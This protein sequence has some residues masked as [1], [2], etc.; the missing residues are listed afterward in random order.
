DRQRWIDAAKQRITEGIAQPLAQSQLGRDL[1]LLIKRRLKEYYERCRRSAEQ[2]ATIG[3][4]DDYVDAVS[5]LMART[6]SW[7][8]MDEIDQISQAISSVPNPKV[9]PKS[10]DLPGKDR[11]K[12]VVDEIR[13]EVKPAGRLFELLRF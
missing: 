2:I 8:A 1:V 6:E 11:A 4:F 9:L 13:A 5:E 10:S 7:L 12:K 3:G